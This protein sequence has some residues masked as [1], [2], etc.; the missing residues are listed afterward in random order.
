MPIR[1]TLDTSGIEEFLEEIARL[2]KNI[3]Q[4]AAK[5]LEIG[6]DVLLT[7]MLNRVPRDTG[8]LANNL[9]RTEPEQDGNYIFILV[10][11]SKD[12]DAKTARYGTAQEYGTSSMAAHSYI[13]STIDH[14]M[15]D[16][17]I[18]MNE[19]LLEQIKE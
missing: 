10:G 13:R 8:N 15:L 11:I 9:K 2:G 16:A 5:A 14:D 17:R 19:K 12:V 4:A 18:A 7:G 3:D 6:G 1:A